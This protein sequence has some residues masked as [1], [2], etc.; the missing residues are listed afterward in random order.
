[1]ERK[2]NKIYKNMLFPQQTHN[3]S[4]LELSY[5]IFNAYNVGQK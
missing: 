3:I 5:H 2:K 1:M 4:L